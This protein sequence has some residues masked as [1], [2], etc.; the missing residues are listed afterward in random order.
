MGCPEAVTACA[1]GRCATP[2]RKAGAATE[3]GEIRKQGEPACAAGMRLLQH[4][5][6][7][8]T[9]PAALPP[10]RA[11]TAPHMGPSQAC[12][13]S[14]QPPAL[15]PSPDPHP[16]IPWM[17]F[18]ESKPVSVTPVGGC[19]VRGENSRDFVTRPQAGGLCKGVC[20]GRSW[21]AWHGGGPM[22]GLAPALP[23]ALLLLPC[24]IGPR[25]WLALSPRSPT[26]SSPSLRH[27]LVSVPGW[28]WMSLKGVFQL[29]TNWVR[30]E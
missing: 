21:G 30:T 15:P 10:S 6:P 18:Q 2:G 8:A 13:Q 12:V 11:S 24:I 20:L 3:H 4:P 19:A 5:R 7:G 22:A 26:L 9:R 27:R 17:L 1:Q 29:E 16:G 25:V 28:V 14:T 23:W